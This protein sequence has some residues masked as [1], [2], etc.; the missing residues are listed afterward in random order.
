MKK[1]PYLCT[2]IQKMSYKLKIKIMAIYK[3][4]SETVNLIRVNGKAV[5]TE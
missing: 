3:V 4:T 2:V 1:T 5:L